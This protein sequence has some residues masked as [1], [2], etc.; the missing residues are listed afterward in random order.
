MFKHTL[1]S[2]DLAKISYL[3]FHSLEVVSRCRNP[4]LQ[5]SEKYS[6][7]NKTDFSNKLI[8]S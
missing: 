7:S 2:R 5:V 6:A 8:G 3:I 1:P 4:Q